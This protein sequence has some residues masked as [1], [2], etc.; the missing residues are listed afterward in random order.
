MERIKQ[1]TGEKRELKQEILD[2]EFKG[3]EY[4]DRGKYYDFLLGKSE[5]AKALINKELL[6]G[7]YSSEKD[8]EF[9]KKREGTTHKFITGQEVNLQLEWG[10]YG[11]GLGYGIEIAKKDVAKA[12]TAEEKEEIIY[13]II[14]SLEKLKSEC[15]E[16]FDLLEEG[17]AL[18]K[19]SQNLNV[20]F[21]SYFVSQTLNQN[22]F[23]LNQFLLFVKELIEKKKRLKKG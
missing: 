11:K 21:S 10:Q 16:S 6:G 15:K 5:E 12:K 19:A 20:G 17:R 23:G 2:L 18:A 13:E 22:L 1:P 14:A 7:N 8:Q 4:R 3:D 9:K